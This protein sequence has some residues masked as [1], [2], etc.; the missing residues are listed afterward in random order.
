MALGL[1]GALI[2]RGVR[3]PEDISVVGF[4]AMPESAYFNPPLTTIRQNFIEVGRQ[5][6]GLL[7]DLID[8]RKPPDSRIE[9]PFELVVRGSSRT[10][11]RRNYFPRSPQSR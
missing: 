9:I 3:V 11:N 8:G 2:E 1:I 10:V 6:F 4:D 7:R 5:G